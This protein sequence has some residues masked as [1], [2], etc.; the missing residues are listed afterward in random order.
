MWHNILRYSRTKNME[1]CDD[2]N[3]G[4]IIKNLT[5][6]LWTLSFYRV[7][8]TTGETAKQKKPF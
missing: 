6:G 3:V 7:I 8:R 2:T 5:K 1:I 4:K